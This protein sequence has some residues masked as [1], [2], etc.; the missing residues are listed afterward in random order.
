MIVLTDQGLALLSG[1]RGCCGLSGFLDD[2]IG[3]ARENWVIV[4]AVGVLLLILV[5][6]RR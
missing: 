1:E 2:P 6:R 4:A 5:L 3:W